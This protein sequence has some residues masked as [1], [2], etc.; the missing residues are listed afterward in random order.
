MLGQGKKELQAGPLLP[1]QEG[2]TRFQGTVQLERAATRMVM[3]CSWFTSPLAGFH[4][5]RQAQCQPSFVMG[6][7]QCPGNGISPEPLMASVR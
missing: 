5:S 1:W 7:L 2:G 6:P 4:V 3:A